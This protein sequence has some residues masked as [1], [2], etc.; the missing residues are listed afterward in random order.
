VK[1]I[2][3]PSADHDGSRSAPSGSFVR[4]TWSLPSA[5][6]TQMS[7]SAPKREKAIFV[8][9]GDQ[10]APS[11]TS[12][13]FVRFTCPLPS[14][15]MTQISPRLVGAQ[16]VNAMCALSGDQAGAESSSVGSSVKSVCPVPSV[17]MTKMSPPVSPARAN[18]IFAPLGDQAGVRSTAGSSVNSVCPLPSAF[19]A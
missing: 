1:A 7:E 4:F 12:A 9:S 6:M 5:F 8:P 3:D 11:S 17:F 14:A 19:I 16:R 15:F 13:E 2:R 10:A 18:A